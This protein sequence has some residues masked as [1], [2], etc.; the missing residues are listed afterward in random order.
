[1]GVD[2]LLKYLS[3]QGRANR[4]RYWLTSFAIIGLIILGALVVGL[5]SAMLR[6]LGILAVPLLLVVFVAALA[7][8]ARRLHDRNKSAWWLL[9]FQGLPMLFS[10]LRA[11]MVLGGGSSAQGPSSLVALIGF[12]FSIWALVELGFLRGT[13]GPNRFGEDPLSPP[14]EEV[15]A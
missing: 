14:L 10:G 1:V 15:F 8:G 12:C 6:I 3:F 2:N 11:L 5:L 9:V 4:K 7:V 13:A